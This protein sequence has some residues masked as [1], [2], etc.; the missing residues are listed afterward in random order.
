MQAG[1]LEYCFWKPAC[2]M[3]L[4]APKEFISYGAGVPGFVGY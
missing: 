4:V 3:S 1:E 2:D